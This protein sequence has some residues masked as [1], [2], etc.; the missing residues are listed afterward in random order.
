VALLGLLVLGVERLHVEDGGAIV[1]GIALGATRR[2]SIDVHEADK[3]PPPG[4]G[5]RP[6]IERRPVVTPWA[7]SASL[8]RALNR[9]VR[10]TAL[11]EALAT[12][13]AGRL[14]RQQKSR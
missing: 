1:H 5:S 8:S 3:G 13:T 11:A 6:V 14:R 2:P 7:P 4:A 10:D 12:R 9:A